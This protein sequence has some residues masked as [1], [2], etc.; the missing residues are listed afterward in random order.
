MSGHIALMSAIARSIRSGTKCASP[1]WMS[2]RWA[3]VKRLRHAL[4]VSSGGGPDLPRY[5]DSLLR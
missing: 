2:D 1:Q 5:P 4:S 3:I